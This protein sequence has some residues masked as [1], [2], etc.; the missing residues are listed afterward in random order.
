ML[1]NRRIIL[2]LI[3]LW[4]AGW[5]Y[6]QEVKTDSGIKR[7]DIP[8]SYSNI[9]TD[10]NGNLILQVNGEKY[11]MPEV[12]ANRTLERLKGNPQATP[13]GI[14]FDFGDALEN[15]SLFY[16]LINFEDT[17]YPQPVYFRSPASILDG[18]AFVN[19]LS[20]RGRYDM[21]GWEKKEKGII[22]Y[23]VINADGE[24]LYD[25][26]I[27]F[28]GKSPFAIDTTL[29]EG[30]FINLLQHNS[31]TISF[32]TN[33]PVVATVEVDGRTYQ[34]EGP[35]T[36][37]EIGIAGLM[38]SRTYQYGIFYGDNE[39]KY[40]FQTAPEAGTRKSFTFSYASDSR[41]GPGGGERSFFGANVY[42]MKKIMALARYKGSA[43]IQ[44]TGDLI[45]GYKSDPE[46]IRLEYANWKRS[47]EPQARYFPIMTTIGNHE[48]VMNYWGLPTGE[49]YSIDKFPYDQVSTEQIFTENF[50]MPEDGPDS[51]DG[52]RYDPGEKTVDFPSYKEN[53][54]SYIYDNVAMIVLN[55]NYWYSPSTSFVN[56][57]S[58]NIHAYVMD[59]QLQWL[60]E[61]IA[62]L[63]ENQDIDH[64][65]VTIHTPVFPNGGHVSDDM[66]YGGSNEKRPY[67][68]GKA[69]EKG[70]IERRDEILQI[71]INES[72]KVVAVLT[73]DEH[74]YCKTHITPE[75]DIYPSGWNKSKLKRNRSIYQINNGAAGAPYYSQEITPWTPYTTGFTT[76]NALVFFHVEGDK[77]QME[78]LNPDTLDQ[79][80]ELELK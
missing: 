41:T 32:E 49:F 38:P 24:I 47:V 28:R 58:G 80:D 42:I 54:Y 69:V 33:F 22:G 37:H 36:R 17:K 75:T 45:T 66:W 78:V 4:T 6:G 79:V 56:I 8:G 57:T 20:L 64:V 21:V 5:V 73:G 61:K 34:S 9:S 30:P 39:E 2:S 55:S 35:V 27:G 50:V 71:L 48:S 11:I 67:V 40:S 77:I 70:I 16:G 53:V 12:K 74:N 59:N 51:E 76:Q 31:V 1:I 13:T 68:A 14:Y 72:T 43:F 18:K 29:I 52:S 15:G 46:E 44:F 23:R 7:K 10:R 62:M 25:G 3:S 65:F 19:L 60:K 63:E 26:K